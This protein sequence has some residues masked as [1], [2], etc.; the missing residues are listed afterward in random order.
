[1]LAV[2]PVRHGALPAGSLETVAECDGRRLLAGSAPDPTS[3]AGVASTV[4]TVELGAFQPARWAD[5]LARHCRRLARRGAPGLVRTAATWPR[6]SPTDW[7]GTCSPRPPTSAS[8][9]GHA[10]PRRWADPRRPGDR[11]AGGG[12]AAA[13]RTRRAVGR[14]VPIARHAR[15]RS[16]GRDEPRP[17]RR[18]D[19]RRRGRCRPGDDRP[20]RGGTHRRRRRRA[21]QPGA[22]APARLGRRRARRRDRGDARHHRPRL[23]RSPAPD[24]HDR[25]RRR[26]RRCTSP[27]G[28]AERCSTRPGSVRRRTSSA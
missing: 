27:S 26:L 8:D 19:A 21:R 2:V 9:R 20:E 16:A 14:A 3:L 24:R 15:A 13:R 23:A 7:A 6:G 5:E 22:T 28:S 17:P 12:D 18:A 1:M 10:R 25:R 11:R 4:T